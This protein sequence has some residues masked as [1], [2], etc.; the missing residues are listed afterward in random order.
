MKHFISHR[1]WTK[2]NKIT[3][4]IHQIIRN[5]LK[6]IWELEYNLGI[7]K[8]EDSEVYN[9]I[10]ENWNIPKK[11]FNISQCAWRWAWYYTLDNPYCRITTL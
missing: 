7:T 6:Y 3:L 5:K 11:A 8:G 1:V 2:R 9:F 10:I 4:R